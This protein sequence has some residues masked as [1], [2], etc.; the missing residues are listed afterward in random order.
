[1]QPCHQHVHH[2]PIRDGQQEAPGRRDKARRGQAV[3]VRGARVCAI[4]WYFCF[5]RLQAYV[6]SCSTCSQQTSLQPAPR[7]PFDS[8]PSSIHETTTLK[9]PLETRPVTAARQHGE[10]PGLGVCSRDP[11]ALPTGWATLEMET[12]PT[13]ALLPG[14]PGGQR[15]QAGCSPWGCKE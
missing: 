5:S 2:K 4:N 3:G 15:S 7:A 14:T 11:G 6:V 13:P 8:A 10:K 1:M 9:S 12:A